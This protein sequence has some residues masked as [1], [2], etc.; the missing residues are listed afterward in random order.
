M[1]LYL[2]DA[3]VDRLA[4]MDDAVAA[5]E[6]GFRHWRRDGTE[7]L[8]RQRLPLPVRS[9]NLMAASSPSLG[10]CGLKAYFGGCAHVSLYSIEE[11]RLL[12]MIEASR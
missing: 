5:V 10:I 2:T 11:K 7:N 9:L 6:D 1:S 4:T 12:A 3:D 8:P